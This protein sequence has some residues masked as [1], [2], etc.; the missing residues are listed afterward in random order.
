[1]KGILKKATTLL[2]AG[3]VTLGVLTGCSHK[4]DPE[5]VDTYLILK[6]TEQV[7]TMH[8]A[9]TDL[10]VDYETVCGIA[11]EWGQ[12]G[13]FIKNNEE[14][15]A[16]HN[17]EFGAYKNKEDIHPAILEQTQECEECFAK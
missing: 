3:A 2:L 1:M 14:N 4:A 7:Y 10:W 15:Y 5:K 16:R 13:A 9:K 17:V 12:A 11:A 6:E 8:L